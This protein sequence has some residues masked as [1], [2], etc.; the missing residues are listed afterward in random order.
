MVIPFKAYDI[1]WDVS[2]D[3]VITCLEDCSPED[4]AEAFDISVDEVKSMGE[5]DLIEFVMEY[6]RHCPRGC[7]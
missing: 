5:D 3:D 4:I 2:D 1:D 6:L 7:L